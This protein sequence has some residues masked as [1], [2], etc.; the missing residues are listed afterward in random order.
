[1]RI[2]DVRMARE[3]SPAPEDNRVSRAA[4]KWP[5]FGRILPDVLAFAVGLGAAWLLGWKTTDLVW[6]L[7]LCSLVLGYLTI[8]STVGAGLYLG[9]K[10]I[11]HESFLRENRP[12]A[13]LGGSLVAIFFLG[14]FSLHFCGFHAG[15]AVFLSSFFPVKGLPKNV[16]F[17]AF[18]NPFLLWKTVIQHLLVVYGIFLIPAVVAE[19]RNIFAAAA[20]AVRVARE[21]IDQQK[22]QDFM[23]SGKGREKSFRDPFTRPYI[24]VIRMHL[25]IFFFAF[26]AMLKV[27]SFF[28][29]G[30]VYFVY[31]FPWRVFREGSSLAQN[32][33]TDPSP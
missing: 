26:C 15:H 1:M 2:S 30:V 16:F 33:A 12:A 6:S 24:N 10:V 23:Q 27:E 21:G 19:R 17:D 4:Y 7:W 22:V 25:L 18:M 8:L 32:D 28:V 14:F 31:F 29:F 20:Q 5:T 3:P 11:F 9:A 13:I